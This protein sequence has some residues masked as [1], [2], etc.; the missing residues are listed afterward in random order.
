MEERLKSDLRDIKDMM[1]RSSR[2]ISLSG[3]S[4]IVV[5]II[6]LAGAY[7]AHIYVYR[8]LGPL[9][10][11]AIEI[12]EDFLTPLISIGSVTLVAAILSALLITSHES[13][14]NNQP[15]WD[16]Q[17]KRLL[18][19][20]GIPLVTGGILCLILLTRGYIALLAPMTL[21]FHGLALVNASQYTIKAIRGLGLM[22]IFTGL[23]AFYF[24][25]YGLVLWTFGFGLCHILYGVIM[26]GKTKA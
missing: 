7:L 26:F 3:T 6:A 14:R 23:V 21:I 16:I 2:F 24:V 20:L 9:S 15:I 22:L 19:N 17:S 1:T 12:S 8:S 13:R 18:I 4:G 25:E 10:Y 11:S 5:G